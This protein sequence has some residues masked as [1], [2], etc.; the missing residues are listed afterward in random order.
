MDTAYQY[1]PLSQS[2]I[3]VMVLLKGSEDACLPDKLLF[4]KVEA[5]LT[6]LFYHSQKDKPHSYEA[7]SYVWG[8]LSRTETLRCD[9]RIINITPNLRDALRRLRPANRHR[10][11][12][13]DQICINQSDTDER[14]S[15]VALMG[16]ICKIAKQVVAC[17]GPDPDG[18]RKLAYE[19]MVGIARGKI[20]N[21]DGPSLLGIDRLKACG[22]PQ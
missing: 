5:S 20:G 21:L 7:L 3:R 4:G 12:W 9:G 10:A 8:S 11:L 16:Q 15:Q 1:L 2:E 13:V 17:L 19:F 22:L 14:S 6:R 18:F